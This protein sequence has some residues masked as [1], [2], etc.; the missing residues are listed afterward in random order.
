MSLL[1]FGF[2]LGKVS[3][4]QFGR[5]NIGDLPDVGTVVYNTGG[6]DYRDNRLNHP[7][8]VSAMRFPR[9]KTITNQLGGTTTFTYGC[10]LYTSPSPRD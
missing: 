6:W 4:I 5:G 2:Q 3:F 1:Q 10:L 9:I 8:G 7:G